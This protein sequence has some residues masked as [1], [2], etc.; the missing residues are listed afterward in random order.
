MG[1]TFA[2]SIAS[3]ACLTA[4]C[5]ATITTVPATPSRGGAASSIITAKRQAVPTCGTNRFTFSALKQPSQASPSVFR[6]SAQ[7]A[8]SQALLKV[9]GVVCEAT[10][11]ST[12]AI[13]RQE[14]HR[15]G[16][17]G[18]TLL[19]YHCPKSG[20]LVGESDA[21]AASDSISLAGLFNLI[22]GYRA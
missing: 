19:M 5:E 16:R 2:D 13:R 3:A 8:S 4:A 22:T 7:G 14:G 9:D 6:I 15:S 10:R 1:A 20:S 12:V 21:P 11:L 17:A 18:L